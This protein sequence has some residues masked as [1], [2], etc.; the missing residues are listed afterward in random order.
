MPSERPVSDSRLAI[1]ASDPAFDEA[2]W[3]PQY[4]S[5]FFEVLRTFG[6]GVR[7]QRI[8]DLGTG[9]GRLAIQFSRQGSHVIGVDRSANLIRKARQQSVACELDAA[10]HIASPHETGLPA[11]RFDAAI[12]GERAGD[13][14]GHRLRREIDRLLKPG[15]LIVDHG[16]RWLPQ[17][18]PVAAAVED[19]L[20]RFHCDWARAGWDG[21]TPLL[22]EADQDDFA[23]VATVVFDEPIPFTRESWRGHVRTREGIR[24]QLT[25]EQLRLLDAEHETVLQSL[26]GE[27][28]TVLHRVFA[29]LLRPLD[30][31]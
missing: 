6:V 12:C 31:E 30:V 13:L 11:R 3:Q 2:I 28:F 24:D 19:L 22:P 21:H 26:T 27:T 15:G 7:H 5:R 18:D 14:D 16:L 29:R 4:P 1:D 25:D 8:V 9:I 10:F 17:Q 23:L 20:L